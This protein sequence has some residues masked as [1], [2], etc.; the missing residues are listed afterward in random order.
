MV[1]LDGFSQNEGV[2]V[3]AATNLP[4]VLDKALI[5]P[6]RFD[7]QITISLP[8]IRARKEIIEH[9][10]SD[11]GAPDVDIEALA[12]STTGFSGADLF[13]MVNTAAIQATKANMTKITQRLLRSA[14]E[15]VIMGP[16]RRS[17]TVKPEIKRLTAFHESGH[18]V[19]ALHTM[20]ASQVVKATLLPRG[21]AL[22]FVKY[23][24]KDE[25]MTTKEELM[26]RL[27][28]A[29]GGRVAEELIFGKDKATQVCFFQIS[30]VFFY[31]LNLSD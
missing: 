14:E 25:L 12:K 24:Q 9:Y 16:E 1:E 31:S 7:R 20:A 4:D 23:D 22:G 13:N 2:I 29:M 10:I 26:A 27:D 28:I 11:R 21:Q 17:L 19:V 15:T 5:R 6:G 8:D 18:A 3:L 30:F